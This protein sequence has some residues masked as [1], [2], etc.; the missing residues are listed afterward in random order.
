M[1]PESAHAAHRGSRNDGLRANDARAGGAQCAALDAAEQSTN[2]HD[3]TSK[4]I[5]LIQIGGIIIVLAGGLFV[6]ALATA[7]S[8]A[9][10][11]ACA[12]ERAAQGLRAA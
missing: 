6:G 4:S 3:E 2:I 11:R 10:T 1:V 7:A 9:R 12:S 5:A 8:M